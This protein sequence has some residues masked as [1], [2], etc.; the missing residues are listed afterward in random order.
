[1]IISKKHT[2]ISLISLRVLFVLAASLIFSSCDNQ[3]LTSDKGKRLQTAKHRVE[4]VLVENTSVSLTQTISG[5]LEAVTKIRLYNDESGR[6]I[7]MPYHEGDFVKRGKVLIQLDNAL[8]KTDVAKAKASKQRAKLDLERVKKLLPK[9]IST[10]EEVTHAK[11]ELD[12]AAAEEKHQ[13]TRLKR[14]TIKAPID[15]LITRRLYEPG[16]LLTQHS[17]IQT[18]ID[19]ST[20]RLKASL[21]ERWIPLVTKD[22]D[23]SLNISALGDKS[24]SAK[25][26][27]IHPTINTKTHKGIIEI[28]LEPVPEGAKAGQFVNAKINLKATH[29]LIIP[30]HTVHFEPEGAYT[31]RVVKNDDEFIAK[32]VYITQGQQFGSVTEVLS[33][34][35]VG[36]KIVTRGHLGLRDGKKVEITH[37]DTSSKTKINSSSNE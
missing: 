7:K 35:K 17:H 11:T 21:A 10:E 27:R 12:L 22:Q 25:I 4:V 8:I 19:P 2:G 23:V 36:D 24:F 6:I 20:L 18:I 30:V 16:D 31:Y 5:T 9:K 29:R 32:K 15:G 33:E 1:M 37:T 34:L 13:L 3:E 26:V 14:T 28:N